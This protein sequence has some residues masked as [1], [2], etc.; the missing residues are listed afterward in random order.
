VAALLDELGESAGASEA[1]AG[2][3][4]SRRQRRL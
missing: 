2:S 1:A 3:T 4:S